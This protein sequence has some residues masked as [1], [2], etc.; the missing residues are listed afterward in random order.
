MGEDVVPEGCGVV[1]AD[2]LVETFLE[3]GDDDELGCV[4]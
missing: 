3:V 4:S 2:D 1:V